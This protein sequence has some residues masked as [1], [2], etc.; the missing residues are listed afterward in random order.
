MDYTTQT[1]RSFIDPKA[2]PPA[3]EPP[4]KIA[5]LAVR[6]LEACR[7]PSLIGDG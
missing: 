4:C 5:D 1:R 2:M 6:F 7:V 3:P